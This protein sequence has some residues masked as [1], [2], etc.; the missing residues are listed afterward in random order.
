MY[1]IKNVKY[2]FQNLKLFWTLIINYRW[3]NGQ[4]SIFLVLIVILTDLANKLEKKGTEVIKER[5]PK[6]DQIRRAVVIMKRLSD[7]MV[8]LDEEE[9]RSHYTA[10][11]MKEKKERD[12][13]FDILKG[14]HV[15]GS[16]MR[17]WWD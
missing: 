10:A 12:E 2:F 8:Y 13:L 15:P 14:N 16:D 4:E 17:G 9:H 5:Q 3:F 6:I 7:G 11:M 1:F